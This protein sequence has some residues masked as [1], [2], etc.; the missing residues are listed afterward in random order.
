MISR[1]LEDIAFL[2]AA[3]ALTSSTPLMFSGMRLARLE[4][5]SHIGPK[6][7][8]GAKTY[9]VLGGGFGMFFSFALMLSGQDAE[10]PIYGLAYGP[11]LALVGIWCERWAHKAPSSGEAPHRDLVRLRRMAVLGIVSGALIGVSSYLFMVI[12]SAH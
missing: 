12:G 4:G 9:G 8:A 2:I 11:L 5:Y 7:E 10:I 3:A 1:V 6:V